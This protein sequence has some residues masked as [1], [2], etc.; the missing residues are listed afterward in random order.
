MIALVGIW[1]SLASGAG[2][3]GRGAALGQGRGPSASLTYIANVPRQG[4]RQSYRFEPYAVWAYYLW[5]STY[6]P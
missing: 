1:Q 5:Y 3:E 6:N 4:R 2:A